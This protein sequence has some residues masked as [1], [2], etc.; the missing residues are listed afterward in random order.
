MTVEQLQEVFLIAISIVAIQL[1]ATIAVVLLSELYPRNR[2]RHRVRDLVRLQIA[3]E[4]VRLH[5]AREQVHLQTTREQVRL[6][7]AREQVRLQMALRRMILLNLRHGVDLATFP[8]NS[9]VFIH[10]LNKGRMQAHNSLAPPSCH[11]Q[12]LGF[13]S[14]SK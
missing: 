5:M 1:Q 3:R 6:H 12:K 14:N 13:V 9:P 4:Q 7:M 10:V 8:F 11:D 2:V